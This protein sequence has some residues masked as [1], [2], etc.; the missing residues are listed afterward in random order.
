MV[1]TGIAPPRLQLGEQQIRSTVSGVVVVVVVV[2]VAWSLAR[3]L[4][5]RL[6][7]PSPAVAVSEVEVVFVELQA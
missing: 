1:A 6:T 5:D 7:A 2:V 3:G 4:T